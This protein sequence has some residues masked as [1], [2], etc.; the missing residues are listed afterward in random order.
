MSSPTIA[1]AH[2]LGRPTPTEKAPESR[3][4][5]ERAAPGSTLG[6][7][8]MA[9]HTTHLVLACGRPG[10]VTEGL[11]GRFDVLKIPKAESSMRTGTM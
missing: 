8:S 1:V 10:L 5:P 7:V 4:E 9:M 3:S 6:S 2:R 11:W